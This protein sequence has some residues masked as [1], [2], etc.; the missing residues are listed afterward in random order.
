[1]FLTHREVSAQ[2]AVFRLLGLTMLSCSVKRAFVPTDLPDNRVRIL[3]ASQYLKTL[4]P[5]SEDICMTGLVQRYTERPLSLNNMCLAD[6][7][8]EYDVCY[9]ATG[10]RSNDHDDDVQP[11]QHEESGA[12]DQYDSII[13]LNDG[14]GKTRRRKTRAILM[15][16]EFSVDT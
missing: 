13:T 11:P 6:F 10:Q 16:H 3:K 12:A 5:D 7:V 4:D 9:K 1:V 15:S 14:M 8:V 2:E